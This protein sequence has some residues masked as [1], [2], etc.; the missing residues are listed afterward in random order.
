MAEQQYVDCAGAKYFNFGCNGG[1]A[2]KAWD[3]NQNHGQMLESE[4]PYTAKDGSCS[5]VAADGKVGTMD[6]NYYV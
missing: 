4:Y 6:G 5:Y 1:N 3:Y 2:S